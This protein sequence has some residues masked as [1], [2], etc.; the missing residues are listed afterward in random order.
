MQDMLRGLLAVLLVFAF[1]APVM[2]QDLPRTAPRPLQ[3]AL[4]AAEGGRW[5]VAARLARRDGPAAAAIIEWLRLRAGLGT[6][7]D[8]LAFLADHPDWPDLDALRRASEP[9][10]AEADAPDILTFYSDYRPRTGTGALSYARARMA[11]GQHGEAEA[12]L[13]LAWRTLDLSP[14][15][16]DA[17]LAAHGEL[18]APHHAARLRMAL[19]RGLRDVKEMLPLVDE[20]TRR[21]A[22]LRLRIEAGEAVDEDALPEGTINDPGIAYA[23]FQRH[24]RRDRG[25]AAIALILRQSEIAGGLG[26]PRRWAGWRRYLARTQMRAGNIATAY[27]LASQHQ[28]VDGAAYADLEWLSGYVALRYL[29]APDLALDHFQRFRAAVET[30]ISLGRAG[31]WIGRAQEALGDD[32]AA[33]IAYAFG[34]RYQTSFYGLLAA[35]R[36]GL[37]ADPALTGDKNDGLWRDSGL[38][39][40]PLYKAMV[41]LRM[42]GRSW[43]ARRF[44][45]SLSQTLDA[46]GLADL[47]HALDDM[48]DSYLQVKLGKAAARRGMVIPGAYYPLHPLHRMDLP[49]PAELALAVARR[50]SEFNPVVRSGA[51]AVGLMQL[52]PG[53]AADM[54]RALDLN[55]AEAGALTDW[56]R[57]ARLGAAYLARLSARFD[58]N[59]ILVAAGYNAGPA[60][61]PRWIEEIGDPRGQSEAAIVDWI[62]HI[63]FRETR[64]YVMRVAESLPVYRARLGKPALPVPFSEEL[65]GATLPER[66]D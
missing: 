50:E 45:E 63:P 5:D 12:S 44:L 22:E 62:E 64:N 32:A 30:P 46:R 31:Y 54:A 27:R 59:V 35:E 40:Q 56:R 33:R 55:G 15:E 52:M 58:G 43:L 2:A 38:V 18:L 53:T 9:A 16:H 36:A 25:E 51:G 11:A 24:L 42:T 41:L 57:N 4:S 34:A 6:P 10:M 1:H 14:A 28:L 8:V 48:G 39:R 26:E 61:P 20:T 65:S 19:W 7:T 3:S 21:L 13:V 37:S 17:F 29:D 66:M 60:R 23:L 49:V 47:G